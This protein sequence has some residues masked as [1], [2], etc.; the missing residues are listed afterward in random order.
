MPA[1]KAYQERLK[2]TARVEFSSVDC[3]MDHELAGVG[4]GLGGGFMNTNEL[5]VMNFHEA[6]W[7]NEE[8]W[9]KVVDEEHKCMVEN[10]VWQPVKLQDVPKGA[11]VLT[12]TWAC[13]QKANGVK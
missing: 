4:A 11:K 1:E 5:K 10:N 8:G 12:L 3:Q 6:I 13:K 9:T 2:E 7:T